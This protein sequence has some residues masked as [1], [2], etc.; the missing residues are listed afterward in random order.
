MRQFFPAREP[1]EPGCGVE[2]VNP[3]AVGAHHEVAPLVLARSGNKRTSGPAIVPRATL[4]TALPPLLD[5]AVG[6]A[7]IAA[8]FA[9]EKKI[10]LAHPHLVRPRQFLPGL[11]LAR[12][13]SP[14]V[15]LLPDPEQTG[16]LHGQTAEAKRS[17]R[18]KV[19]HNGLPVPATRQLSVIGV[20]PHR[21]SPVLT[22]RPQTHSPSDIDAGD[23]AVLA[24]QRNAGVLR[25][26]PQVGLA[27]LEQ[28]ED[29]AA[30]QPRRVALIEL[31]EV[32]AIEARQAL[33]CPQP[34][35][36]G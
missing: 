24:D 1:R 30:V 33:G 22:D 8:L 3:I 32:N 27:V 10:E 35:L 15:P 11:R 20:K 18:P 6:Q 34:Q 5:L 36:A 19:P 21:A 28:L 7:P 29:A 23:L 9:G 26:N 31:L 16:V 13:K 2:P 25:A 14:Q 17:A 4:Q 12:V